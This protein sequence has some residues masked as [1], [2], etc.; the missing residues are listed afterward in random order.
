MSDKTR[1]L[2]IETINEV[3]GESSLKEHKPKVVW[4]SCRQGDHSFSISGN[5]ELQCT[6]CGV[7]RKFMPHKDKAFL[8]KNNIN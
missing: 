4:K 8:E 6:K 7:I 1:G 2:W 3:T 5:R